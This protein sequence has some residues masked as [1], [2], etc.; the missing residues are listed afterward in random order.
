MLRKQIVYLDCF[1]L[2]S[3]SLMRNHAHG[4]LK[5]KIII[6]K[7]IKYDTNMT[8]DEIF[9]KLD[10]ATAFNNLRRDIML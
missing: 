7:I 6:I 5:E 10:F 4:L 8:E 1:S 2:R 9:V 3:A